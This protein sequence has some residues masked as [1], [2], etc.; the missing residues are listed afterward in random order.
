VIG[1][2]LANF[3]LNGFDDLCQ[4]TQKTAFDPEKAKFIAEHYGEHYNK[5][6]GIVQKTLEQ[7]AFRYADDIVV[8]SND[9]SQLSLLKTRIDTFLAIRGIEINP[10]KSFMIKWEHNQKF[11]FLGFTFHYILN[12]VQS[13]ITEQRTASG[14]LVLRGGLYVYPSDSSVSSFKHKIKSVITSN[15][16]SSPF[17]MVKVLNPIIRG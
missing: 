8:V 12:P 14:E 17:A 9:M 7:R 16:N 2:L 1:P 5:G 11:D 4:P 3:T 15:L 6:N 10:A 13:K